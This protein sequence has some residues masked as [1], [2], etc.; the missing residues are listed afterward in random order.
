MTDAPAAP[1]RPVLVLHAPADEP[2]VRGYL[3]P[4]LGPGASGE[5]AIEIRDLAAVEIPELEAALTAGGIAIA[6]IT[7]AFLANPWSRLAELLA[8][9]AAI[10][11]DLEVIPLVLE[12][13][14]LPLHLQAKVRLDLRAHGDWDRET[15]RLR[16]YL[17]RPPPPDPPVP[18]PYPGMRPFEAADAR[19]FHGREAEIDAVLTLVA[20]GER[21]LT[22]IGPSGSGKSSLIAAGV[23]PRLAAQAGAAELVVRTLRPGDAPLRRLAECLEAAPGA[24]PGSELAAAVAAWAGRHP[25][26]RLVVIVDQLEE[27]FTLAP[28]A[29]HDRFAAALRP[30]RDEPRCLLVLALRADFYA[31]LLQSQLWLDGHR[32][33]V[34]LAP[35][36]GAALRAAIERPARAQ[37]V[38][39]EPGLIER[40][41]AD[42][43]G[44]PGVLPLLQETLVQL[45]GRRRRRLLTLADYDAL[46]EGGRSGLAVAISSR[47]D[48]CL[49]DMTP[50]QAV[51]ARRLLLRLVSFGEG[52]PDTRRRQGRAQLA[53]GER[54]AELDAVLRQLVAARLIILDGG[55]TGDDQVDLCHEVL[56]T[57]WPPFTAWVDARRADEQRRRQ[58]QASADEWV[59]RGRGASGLLDDGELAAAVAWRRTDAAVELGES[60]EVTALIDASHDALVRARWRWRL[61]VAGVAAGVVVFTAA[62]ATLI[63]IAQRRA[64]DADTARETAAREFRNNVRLTGEQYRDVGWQAVLTDHPQRAIPYLVAARAHGLDDA[65]LRTLFRAASASSVALALGHGDAVAAASFSD[66]G[67][68]VATASLDGTARIWDA[69]SGAPIVP[70]LV[71]PSAVVEAVFAAGGTRLGTISNDDTARIWDL[72]ARPPSAIV[73]H[74]AARVNA[75]GFSGDGA[76]VVTASADRTARVWSART[77]QPLAPPMIHDA[78]VTNA[79]LSRDGSRVVTTVFQGQTAAIWNAT[80]GARVR[81]LQQAVWTS[82][83]D[84]EAANS[85]LQLVASARFSPDG[86]RVVTSSVDGTARVWSAATGKLAMAPLKHDDWLVDAVFSPD[87]AR[88]ATVGGDGRV[89]I[90]DAA[91]GTAAGPPLEGLSHVVTVAY[92][93]DGARLL[94]LCNDKHVR[95]WDLRGG[96]LIAAIELETGAL[97][98]TISPDG[99]RVVTPSA[100]GVA[101]VWEVRPA[102]PRVLAS[103]GHFYDAA[104]SPDG[105]RIA[106]TDTG[107]LRL[108][109]ASGALEATL[110]VPFGTLEVVFDPSGKRLAAIGLDGVSEIGEAAPARLGPL[111]LEDESSQDLGAG[112]PTEI[113]GHIPA[114]GAFS[115]DGRRFA[116]ATGDDGARVWDSESRQPVTPP[117]KHPAAVMMVRFSPDG[118]RVITA[119]ADGTARIWDAGSGAPIGPPLVHP[120]HSLVIAAVFSPDGGRIA[121]ANS[122]NNVRLWNAASGRLEAILTGHAGWII[123]AAFSPDGARL[124]THS[125]DH[126]ARIWDV[127]TGGLAAPPLEHA[128]RV[129]SAVFSPD[130]ARIV[131][132]SAKLAQVWDVRTG[133][134]L[135][136]P[137]VHSEPLR[138][139]MFSPDGNSVLTVADAV[140]IWDAGLDTRS[141]EAWRRIA[142]DGPFPQLAASVD[143]AR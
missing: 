53:A 50:A 68:R 82:A 38:Y 90:W 17:A 104:Y 58:I 88:I 42:A 81:A 35:L 20:A 73:L 77:G 72:T 110:R 9:N 112:M 96:G 94:A 19:Y 5:P 12:D 111:E 49:R 22:L 3:V 135:T 69:A 83:A 8:M 126:S 80:T 33:H 74:H 92:S 109:A 121:T 86:T 67:A 97:Q 71:H 32:R 143:P 142:G 23:L 76:V 40:L 138:V 140:R 114:R 65:G 117:L 128:S 137:L 79:V 102:A 89:R 113:I 6:V 125:A 18:C 107:G 119:G 16:D 115:P 64:D 26:A 15:R 13:C 43:A 136:P 70:P 93:R 75:I 84:R 133:R 28:R 139:A 101:R 34:D 47:A 105:A 10:E 66:D 27:L 37:D 132:A 61:R 39:F 62:V 57:A 31:E 52:R 2:F 122:D 124:V 78:A 36:R 98:A 127:A 44:E 91:G 54:S 48:R 59:A 141:L 51:I 120:V 129:D 95:I 56:I 7:P 46:G 123:S 99:A 45:W 131:T 103:G 134:P 11:R 100:D 21:E 4:A 87:G 25:G 116:T 29:D 14:A 1:A 41:L 30:L 63:V 85:H 108:W 60:P 130:G 118:R 106:I 24:E 55:G